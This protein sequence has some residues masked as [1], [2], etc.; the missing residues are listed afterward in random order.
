M[1]SVKSDKPKVTDSEAHLRA[2]RAKCA[3]KFAGL[4]MEQ[5]NTQH[6]IPPSTIQGWE[7]T[8]SISLK[9]RS[10]TLKGAQRLTV[11]L[12]KEGVACSVE[13]LMKGT[14]VGPHFIETNLVKSNTKKKNNSLWGQHLAIQNE[15]KAFEE[16]NL[17]A[18][19]FMITDDGLEP[20]YSKGDI[21][22][23]IKQYLNDITKFLNHLC[24]I[25]TASN[26]I[27]VRQLSSGK[28]TKTFTLSCINNQ[29]TAKEPSIENIKLNWAAPIIWHRKPF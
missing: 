9:N 14:G 21:V 24:I 19:V 6:S 7:N 23:G 13:W 11:A 28:R 22:G 4:T 12:Q 25:E 16:N 20:F 10:L 17:N 27:T 8:G 2:K 1:Q 29:T 18:I 3:R 15:I 26:D 5:M